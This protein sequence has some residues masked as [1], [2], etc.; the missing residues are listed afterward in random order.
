MAT[1]PWAWKDTTPIQASL[2]PRPGV[3]HPE[4]NGTWVHKEAE[5]PC[6]RTWRKELYN[7]KT[8]TKSRYRTYHPPPPTHPPH[9]LQ[10][11]G[12][13]RNLTIPSRSVKH[14]K[15]RREGRTS[16][17]P[18]SPPTQTNAW[19]FCELIWH[20]YMP[21]WLNAGNDHIWWPPCR[22]WKVSLNV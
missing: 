8:N 6:Y 16:T 20:V 19:Q 15:C 4:P 7:P 18:L 17:L 11:I 13:E 5:S 9:W 3:F 21:N 1:Y 22:E 12:S 14:Q 2:K 10:L